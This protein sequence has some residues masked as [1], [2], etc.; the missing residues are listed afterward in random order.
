M[1]TQNDHNSNDWLAALVVTAILTTKSYRPVISSAPLSDSYSSCFIVA[2]WGSCHQYW[3]RTLLQTC[4][5]CL[6]GQ[7]YSDTVSSSTA[8]S[9]RWCSHVYR[10][11]EIG[12][13][14][15]RLTP[16]ES[17]LGGQAFCLM[18]VDNRQGQTPTSAKPNLL[19]L[20]CFKSS[21]NKALNTVELFVLL[22]CH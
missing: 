11:Q 10:L 22:S 4:A 7:F 8:S 3:R 19:N 14:K 2:H 15:L 20:Q 16:G 13:S 9:Q 1:Y 17:A 6:S 18:N 12:L 5:G 21:L